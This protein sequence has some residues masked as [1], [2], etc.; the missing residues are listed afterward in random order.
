M[1]KEVLFS[2]FIEEVSTRE[3]IDSQGREVLDK[4]PVAIPLHHSVPPVS[5]IELIHQLYRDMNNSEKETFE[6]ADDFDVPDELGIEMENTP[7]ETFF[8]RFNSPSTPPAEPSLVPG[9]NSEKVESE[10]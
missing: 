10:N 8:D 6:D 3:W 2:P 9:E 1:I 5:M 4:T 7:Y